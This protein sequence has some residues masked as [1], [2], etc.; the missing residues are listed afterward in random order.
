MS[1]DVPDYTR[2]PRGFLRAYLERNPDQAENVR[3]Q[4]G[5]EA[6]TYLGDAPRPAA[7]DRERRREDARRAL[8]VRVVQPAEEAKGQV[9]RAAE[10]V[11][12]GLD[13]V[14]PD[15]PRRFVGGLPTP[16]GLFPPLLFLIVMLLAI[17]PMNA[18]GDTRLALVWKALTGGAH[19]PPTQRELRRQRAWAD[20]KQGQAA[21][22]S[23]AAD[24]A[25]AIGAGAATWDT[26]WQLGGL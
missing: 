11:A 8:P 16:G 1:R 21:V 25:Q 2:D 19:L 26:F 12:R 10:G 17:V 23:L 3:R 20:A 6:G 5:G 18:S 7:S 14:V 9:T 4:L 24:A 15:A 13:A 22:G